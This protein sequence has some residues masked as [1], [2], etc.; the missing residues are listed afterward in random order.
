MFDS[1]LPCQEQEAYP[2]V[3]G[4][5]LI[6]IGGLYMKKTRLF[7]LILAV[8]L[9]LTLI[10]VPVQGEEPS[11]GATETVEQQEGGYTINGWVLLLVTSGL[12]LAIAIPLAIRSGN[13]KYGK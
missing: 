2:I 13:K 9:A 3:G 11:A 7:C 1:R 6:S 8:C 10:F 5:F 12:S 4:L